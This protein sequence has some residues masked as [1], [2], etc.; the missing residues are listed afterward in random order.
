ML[1]ALAWILNADSLTDAL[2]EQRFGVALRLADSALKEHPRDLRLLTARGL[3]LAGMNRT[4]ESLKVFQGVLR[5]RADYVP[6]LKGAAQTSYAARIPSAA[7]FLNRLIALD[8]NDPAA[9]FMAAVLA[10][11]SGD[12]RSA[13]AH[14]EAGQISKEASP[15]AFE[16]YG[17]CLVKMGRA[18]DALLVFEQL[19][20]ADPE[21]TTILR[22]LATAQA[23]AGA[24]G[25]AIRTLNRAIAIKPD[26]EQTYVELAALYL[27]NLDGEHAMSVVQAGLERLPRSARLFGLRG[28]IESENGLHGAA[29]KDFKLSNHLDPESEYG[30]AGLGVLLTEEGRA[31][32]G[33]EFLRLRLQKSPSDPTVN[34]LLAQAI[35]REGPEPG[36]AKFREAEAALI[37]AVSAR[38][39]YAAAHTA[40]G[41]LYIQSGNSARA[42][43]ELQIALRLNG[44]D[45]AALNQL[46][47]LLRRAGRADEAN[48]VTKRLRELV[49][50]AAAS[51]AS[52]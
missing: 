35:V 21:S 37:R 39:D 4:A 18:K 34:Y 6:A 23:A 50:S 27:T 9:H 46:A 24:L 16:I 52:R 29:E 5:V 43:D 32:E 1:F 13:V 28:V 41:K 25:Q 19:I 8:P 40:L 51:E 2:R 10:Y 15:R 7:L 20:R 36:S 11:E 44:S 14:F 33:S 12:A 3:A 17:A 38:P 26:E 45:R 49:M 47:G 31:A 42:I 30:S 48:Q 22:S